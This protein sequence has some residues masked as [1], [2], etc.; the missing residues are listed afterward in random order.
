LNVESQAWLC[1]L[2]ELAARDSQQALSKL[3]KIQDPDLLLLALAAV[4]TGWGKLDPQAAADWLV[5]LETDTQRTSAALGLIPVWAA[6]APADCLNWATRS[7]AGNLREIS[8]VELA[9]TWCSN[10][11]QEALSRFLAL[12]SEAG[13]E[14]GLHAI[15]SQWALNDP[16]AAIGHLSQLNSSPRRDEFLETALVSLSNQDP[17]LTWKYATRFSDPSTVD[18]VRSMALEAIAET[19]PQDAI[20][21]AASGGN[22]ETLLTGIARGLAAND[23]AA[24]Q[25][26]IGSLSDRE[27]AARLSQQ[28]AK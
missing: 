23:S 12:P 20:R 25:A 3:A 2:E 24:A 8:L 19:R 13:S 21:L 10:H 15:V 11:P 14:R 5:G 9:D 16:Q 22:S 6:S 26:W 28:I 1:S 7:P 27:L 18:Y 4:A 17:D